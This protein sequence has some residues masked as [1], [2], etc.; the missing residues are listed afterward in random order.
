MLVDWVPEGA[1]GVILGY[2]HAHCALLV[3]EWVKQLENGTLVIEPS[4]L[5]QCCCCRVIQPLTFSP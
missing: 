1:V 5:S 4:I 3:Q 2:Q